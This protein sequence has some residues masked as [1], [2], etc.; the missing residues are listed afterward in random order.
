MNGGITIS[1]LPRRE[2]GGVRHR[3]ILSGPVVDGCGRE[4]RSCDFTTRN[5]GCNVSA[6][7]GGDVGKIGLGQRVLRISSISPSGGVD[8]QVES[9]YDQTAHVVQEGVG[10][11]PEIRSARVRQVRVARGRR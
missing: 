7:V 11:G 10:C 2:G 5:L 9:G 6:L 4:R 8:V 3:A 1:Y